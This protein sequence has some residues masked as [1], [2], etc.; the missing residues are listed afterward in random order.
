MRY[1]PNLL[2]E[3]GFVKRAL[4]LRRKKKM[5]PVTIALML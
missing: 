4:R 2:L 3:D 5:T 1:S